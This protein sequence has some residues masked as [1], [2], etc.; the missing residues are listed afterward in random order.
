M[1]EPD[2]QP[3]SKPKPPY[4]SFQTFWNF[5]EELSKKPLPPKLDRSLM[6]SKSGTDQANLAAALKAFGLIGDDWTVHASLDSLVA[7]DEDGRKKLLAEIIE[8]FYAEALRVSAENGSEKALSDSFRASFGL[9]S[10]D[11]R[12]KAVTFFLHAARYVGIPLSPNFPTTRSPGS[13]TPQR[14]RKTST[15][16][17]K[18]SAG[19]AGGATSKPPGTGETKVIN[20]GESGAVTITVDVKWL[21]LP[22]DTMVELR[23]AVDA[24]DKLGASTVPPHADNGEADE[25]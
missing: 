8:R 2:Q 14:P 12:R 11:T 13:P 23:K 1:D 16:K 21:S 20:F 17:P 3:D 10:S 9:D 4:F 24:F 25:P 15:R 22:T 19:E 6:K 7:A 18:G 5:I